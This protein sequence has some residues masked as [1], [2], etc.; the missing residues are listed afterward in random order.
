MGNIDKILNEMKQPQRIKE[1]SPNENINEGYIVEVN[2]DTRFKALVRNLEV[3]VKYV[4][5]I[6]K[7]NEEFGI[8]L[9]NAKAK[10]MFN[11]FMEL[12]DFPNFKKLEEKE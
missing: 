5:I 12:C 7:M 4:D 10:R 6:N 9:T 11:M 8:T 3:D 2:S 1:A